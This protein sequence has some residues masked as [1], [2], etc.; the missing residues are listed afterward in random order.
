VGRTRKENR[1][2]KRRNKSDWV[3]RRKAIIS[4]YPFFNRGDKYKNKKPA[5]NFVIAGS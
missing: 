2:N 3:G 5:I 4:S 1:E